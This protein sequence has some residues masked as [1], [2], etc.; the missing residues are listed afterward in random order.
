MKVGDLVR[1]LYGGGY[2]NP[3]GEEKG[4]GIIVRFER[5]TSPQTRLGA[6]VVLIN[7]RE[8]LYAGAALEVLSE[9]R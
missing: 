6:P 7:G 3:T 4:T 1:V 8:W 5:N 2:L 9:G